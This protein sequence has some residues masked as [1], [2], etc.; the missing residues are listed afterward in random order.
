MT[1]VLFLS[2]LTVVSVLLEAL[3]RS[4]G[5]FLPLTV[6]SVF[7]FSYL[8]GPAAGIPVAL[9]AGFLLDAVFGYSVPVSA[10]AMLPAVPAA[11]FLRDAVESESPLFLIPAGALLP[12]LSTL[13]PVLIRGGWNTALELLPHLFLASVFGA[14]LLPAAAMLFDRFG[15]LLALPLFRDVKE[16]RR[17]R[18]P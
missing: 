4:A 9:A 7:Y 13:P 11:W 16:R 6:C 1:A 8:H 3:I 18:T 2:F 12:L 10:L 14:L 5:F 15:A 17:R